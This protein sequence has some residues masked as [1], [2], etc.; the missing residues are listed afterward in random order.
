[1]FKFAVS[2]CLVTVFA[3]GQE[4]DESRTL[5]GFGAHVG[6][7]APNAPVLPLDWDGQARMEAIHAASAAWRSEHAGWRITFDPRTNMPWRAYGPGIPVT[8]AGASKESIT[9]AAMALRNELAEASGISGGELAFVVAA[10]AGRL[11]YCDFAQTVGEA[12]VWNGGLTMRIDDAGRLVM[13]GGRLLDT[14]RVAREPRLS[15]A[16]AFAEASRHL[17]RARFLADA[18][19]MEAPSMRLVVHV[20]EGR[21]HRIPTL[22]WHVEMR[23]ESPTAWWRVFID[24][25]TGEVLEYWNDIREHGHDH[26]DDH[27]AGDEQGV[28]VFD[29]RRDCSLFM[30]PVFATFSGTSTGT[31]HDGVAPQAAPVLRSFNDLYVICN[32]SAIVTD[33][34]GA[35]TFNGGG[36]S[37]PVSS[38][39]DGIHVSTNNNGSQASFIGT[40]S[41]GTLDVV[42][43]DVNSNLAERDAFFFTNKAWNNLILRNPG[44]TLFNA[45]LPANVNLAQTCNAFYNGTSINFFNAGGGCINTAYSGSVVVHEYGHHVTIV[46]YAS[47]ASNIPGGMGEGYADCQSGAVLDTSIVGDGWQGPGTMVRNMNNTCQYPASCGTQVHAAGLVIGACYWH[48]RQIFDTA[49]GAAGKVMMDEYLYQHFHGTPMNEI[50]SML[51]MLLLNDNDAN[52]NNGTPDVDKFYQG[53]TVQHSVPFPIPFFTLSV[54][55]INDTMDQIQN[56]QVHATAVPN[57]GGNITSSTLFYSLNGGSW[58]SAALPN[59]GG[60]NYFGTIPVQPVSTTVNYYVEFLD[61]VGH[62]GKF[63]AAGSFSF[64]TARRATFFFD[65]FEAASGWT[66]ATQQGANDWHNQ[67]PGNPSHPYDP[68]SA[69]E[70]TKCWGNDLTPASNFNGNYPN[71]VFNH[72]TSP[73]INCAGKAGVTLVYR[74]WLTVEESTFDHARIRVS[75]NGGAT[76]TTVWENPGIGHL[77]DTAWN[78]HV[79]DI[80]A[81]A[82]NQATVTIRFELQSD[83]G[84]VFGGW[85]IDAFSLASGAPTLPLSNVG[86]NTPGGLGTIRITGV[87]GDAVILA[88]DVATSGTYYPTVGTLSIDASSPTFLVLFDGSTVIPPSGIIDLIFTVPALTGVT[89]WFEGVLVPATNPPLL[90]TNVLQYTI[91]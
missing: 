38:G 47:H 45:S 56:Y 22:A 58:V 52:L 77:I 66:T 48:T 32:G 25:T 68:A 57:F 61:S 73:T 72:L 1:M 50:E 4:N 74:R 34:T 55:E 82:D 54:D 42:W 16:Q 46:T 84:L 26:A 15:A 87:Q 88:V 64:F 41:T 71:N 12:R 13:W 35:Y 90:V 8:S 5:G 40:G 85:N 86:S 21:D 39:L 60:N 7:Q 31:V 37:V 43:T 23:T 49:Y 17:A 78:E 53:F 28:L 69:F 89:A 9:A 24:A 18:T 76:Y 33:A 81:I 10:K 80:S 65:G 67:S 11:W 83:A 14:S 63:P 3:F 27:E 62:S 29:Y 2:V 6:P 19:L 91:L 51:E 79:L 44:E 20:R 75:I 70:G 36:A 59:V 30:A